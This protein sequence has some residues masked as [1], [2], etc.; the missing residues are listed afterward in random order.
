MSENDLEITGQDSHIV[1]ETG[2]TNSTG[3]A[4][5]GTEAPAKKAQIMLTEKQQAFVK[6][7]Q[8]AA[9][10]IDKPRKIEVRHVLGRDASF[11]E[12]ETMKKRLLTSSLNSCPPERLF[13]IFNATNNDD[14]KSSFTD[15]IQLS[16][17]AQFNPRA[18]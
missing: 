3:A 6:M 17:H 1:E 10:Q 16:M 13:S 12:P 15:H 4:S 2:N 5:G 14:Q 11:K 9:S 7:F 8:S 18:L